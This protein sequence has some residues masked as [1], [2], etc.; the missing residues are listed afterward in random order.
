MDVTSSLVL[1]ITTLCAGLA[2]VPVAS[3]QG[4]WL[5]VVLALGNAVAFGIRARC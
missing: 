3:S 1:A 4:T 5:P 2:W